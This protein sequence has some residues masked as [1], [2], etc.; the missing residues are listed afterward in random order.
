MGLHVVSLCL[1]CRKIKTR[2]QVARVHAEYGCS[3]AP[4]A[5]PG[6]IVGQPTDIGQLTRT[7]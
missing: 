1:A 3:W 7:D 5:G 6:P 4:E 2:A